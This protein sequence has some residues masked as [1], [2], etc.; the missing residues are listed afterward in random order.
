MTVSVSRWMASYDRKIVN[1]GQ[2]GI[3]KESWRGEEHDETS[4]AHGHNQIP[5]LLKAHLS[6]LVLLITYRHGPCRKH[7]SLQFLYDYLTGA[8]V[9]LHISRTLPGDGSACYRMNC[10]MQLATAVLKKEADSCLGPCTEMAISSRAM[11][12][13]RLS[14]ILSLGLLQITFGVKC[15]DG[16]WPS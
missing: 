10:Y 8:G 16:A 13:I 12:S 2:E 15:N 7:I 14:A 1:N 5:T 4:R 11:T 9:L 3:S 6:S